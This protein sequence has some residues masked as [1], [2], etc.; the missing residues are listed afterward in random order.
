MSTTANKT[1]SKAELEQGLTEAAENVAYWNREAATEEQP[2]LR[3][4]AKALH[5]AWKITL[6]ARRAEYDAATK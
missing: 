6:A 1:K 2:Q 4:S 5:G 3:A